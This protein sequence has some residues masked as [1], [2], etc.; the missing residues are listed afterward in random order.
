MD[1]FDNMKLTLIRT[2]KNKNETIGE[3]YVDDEFECYILEDVVREPGVKVYGETAIP[4]GT[5]NVTITYSPRFKRNLPLLNNVPNFSG[6]R[7]HPGNF[8]RDTEGCLLPGTGKTEN[9]VTNSRMAFKKL[10]EKL[11]K[12]KNITITIKD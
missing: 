12:A 5:Y 4:Y 9:S 11:E 1:L 6:I 7:I 8:H 2:Q 10:Y 3:L